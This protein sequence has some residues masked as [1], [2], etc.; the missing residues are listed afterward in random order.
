MGLIKR[1]LVRRH[2][3]RTLKEGGLTEAQVANVRKALASKRML[4]ELC[5]RVNVRAEPAL[6][7]AKAFGDGQILNWLWEHRTE[8]L[9]FV[10]QIVQM[11]M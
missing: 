9:E 11:F 7:G 8:I 6:A 5:S 1:G 3:K 10:M 4:D 2:L